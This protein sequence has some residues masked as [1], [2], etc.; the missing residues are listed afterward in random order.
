MLGVRAALVCALG[1][2]LLAGCGGS[3]SNGP[4]DLLF[5]S[6]RDG[7]YAIFAAHRDGSGAHRLTKDKG[8]PSDP[9]Q[10]FYQVEPAWSPDGT[11]IAFASRRSGTSHIY[12]MDANGGDLR[13]L[14]DSTQDDDH[15]SWSPDGARIVFSREGAIFTVAASGGTARRIGSRPGSAVDPAFS[16]DG[17]RIAYGYRRPGFEIREVFVM[18]ADGTG[19][20]QLTKL[21]STSGL[22]AWSP[23]GRRIAFQS[24]AQLG[25]AEIYTIGVDGKGL[26]RVTSSDSDVIQPAWSPEAGL[27]YVRDGAIWLQS[28]GKERRLTSGNDNDSSP[29]WRPVASK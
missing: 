23:D 25:H 26:R 5:V 6:T 21:E 8:D 15:P 17:G 12:V 9:A 4:P 27:S 20:R 16:P 3:S 28:N 19:V 29:A 11:T 7:D 18:N 22:P 2:L 1:V 13:R 14:T 24:S 10:L